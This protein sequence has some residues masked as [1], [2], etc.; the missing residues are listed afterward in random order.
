MRRSATTL[1]SETTGIELSALEAAL[2]TAKLS[3]PHLEIGTAAGGTLVAMMKSYADHC[4]PRFVVVDTFD[5]FPN[6]RA[7]VEHNLLSSG[8]DP[9]SVDFRTGKSWSLVEEAL[10]A[11]D[12]FSFILID[13]IH[14]AEHVMRDLT[15]TRLLEIDGLVALHDYGPKFPG[16]VWAADRFLRK[17][18]NYERMVLAE[19]LLIL[20]KTAPSATPEVTDF[21]ISLGRALEAPFRWKRSFYKRLARRRIKSG[22][23]TG[24]A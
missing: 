19:T 7:V 11:D 12:R 14:S 3:G 23:A 20:R 10:R 8:L 16:V 21:D 24:T 9:A 18:T 17:H 1:A 13:A 4:R 5:Y 6:Q 15:W 2:Q 22:R